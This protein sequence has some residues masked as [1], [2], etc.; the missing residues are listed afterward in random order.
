MSRTKRSVTVGALICIGTFLSLFATHP[1][2]VVF[3]SYEE[4]VG[5]ELEGVSLTSDG[6]LM[7]APGLV[8]KL[9]T[10][11]AFVYSAVA[12]KT[13]NLFVGTGN[14][15]K[16]FRLSSTGE[17]KEWAKLE[18]AGVYALAVDSSD[19][20]Y[21]GTAPDGKV[22]R[23]DNSGKADIFFDPNDKYIWDL[24]I[25]TRNNLFVAT[26]PR[27]VIYQVDQQGE[28]KTYYDSEDTHIVE[29]EWDLDNHLLAGSASEGLLYRISGPEKGFVLYDSPMEEVKSITVDRYGNVFAAIL[30]G[31]SNL[32]NSNGKENSAKGS[33]NGSS[34]QS[35]VTVSGA[36]K[37]SSLEVC[38]IDKENLVE[39]LYTS[40]EE[41][42]FDLVVRDD[43]RVLIATGNKGRILAVDRDRFVT[44][45]A[46]SGEEQVTQFVDSSKGFYVAASN[47]GKVFQ[48]EPK[49]P[50]KGVYESKVLDAG[51]QALWGHIRWSVLNG[52]GNGVQLFTRSGN[53]ERPDGTWTDWTGPYQTPEGSQINSQPARYLQW[54]LEFSEG[55]RSNALL[56]QQNAVDLVSVTYMQRNVAPKLT[57][58]TIHPPGVAFLKQPRINPASGVPPGGPE[59]AHSESLPKAV[60]QTSSTGT[61]TP[62]RRIFIPGAR[63]FSWK[64]VDPNSD[65]L[66]FSLFLRSQG[67]TQW[68]PVA[69][70]L[71]DSRF[72]L[73]G[74]SYPDGVYFLKVVASD[75]SSNP[76][77]EAQQDEL[78]SKAFTIANAI[79]VIDWAS[80]EVAGQNVVIGFTARTVA[81]AIYQVEFSVDGNEWQLL[82]PKDGIADS[83]QEEFELRLA[84][85]ERGAHT[86][87]V[88]VVD[89]VGN[90]GTHS[91]QVSS[92]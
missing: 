28:S 21:A 20:L 7:L 81:S 51:G 68:N 56:S 65:N 2:E 33:Q 58:I 27:G 79:P 90:L 70:D 42:A 4:F 26:G 63:S 91:T 14:N 69:K 45:V 78:V 9:D 30:S 32:T 46:D 49:P 25:D 92:Q 60:L 87:R 35:T 41:I 61:V 37:G 22:Y 62:A 85:L 40:G 19:R 47:L 10:R 34:G 72:T 38:R 1:T 84:N 39:T 64:A 59:G 66:R 11:E 57:G 6:K 82:Y 53:R 52:S 76:A 18:E 12:D 89:R 86:I 48:L 83:K 67:T 17:A 80:P 77:G 74:V 73:D 55:D 36:Q 29:L 31:S 15:G 3:S 88:R 43:G 44:V 23:F 16:I 13:G 5:G 75:R 54:K 24:A 50:E 71:I 8:Q